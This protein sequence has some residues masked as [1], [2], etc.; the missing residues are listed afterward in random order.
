MQTFTC[1]MANPPTTG[2]LSFLERANVGAG[3]HSAHS[4]I[5]IFRNILYSR[6]R[7]PH[8]RS[9]LLLFSSSDW[10]NASSIFKAGRKMWSGLWSLRTGMGTAAIFCETSRNQ[11]EHLLIRWFSTLVLDDA[12][13]A[14][15]VPDNTILLLA[16]LDNFSK[17]L[18][19]HFRVF[20]APLHF[21]NVF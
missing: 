16:F 9:H 8:V 1:R 20:P 15:F 7:G 4:H 21:R 17:L 5:V 11:F 13:P 3:L 14:D 12:C 10:L 2:A 6:N 18:C 19:A